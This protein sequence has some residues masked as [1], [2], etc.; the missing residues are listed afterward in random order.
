MATRQ[1]RILSRN[2]AIAATA[3]LVPLLVLIVVLAVLQFTAQRDQLLAELQEDATRHNV[4]LSGVVK[5]VR[6]YVLS[7][8]TWAEHYAGAGREPERAASA[9]APRPP[10]QEAH[11][12]M[13]SD[14]L[15]ADGE[16]EQGLAASLSPHMQVSHRTMP[17]LRWSYYFSAGE[18]LFGLFPPPDGQF[19]GGVRSRPREDEVFEQLFEYEIFRSGTPEHNRDRRGYWTEAYLDPGGAGWVVAHALPVY[20]GE[21]FR[22]IVGTAVLLDFLTGFV[23][24]FDYPCGRLWLVNDRDQVLA[25]SDGRTVTGLDLLA[26]ADVLP[27]SLR[28]LPNDQLLRPFE[29]VRRIG[30]TY[31]LSQPVGMAPWHLLF[32]VTPDELNQVLLP[33]FVPYALILAGILLTLLLAH[34]LRQRLIIGPALSL[35]E[36]IRAESQDGH[37]TRPVL[38]AVWRPW[39]DAVADAFAAKRESLHS[40]RE[41]EQH[42][43]AL[44]ELHPVPVVVSRIEDSTV[45]H[46]NQAYA[47][48]FATGREDVLAGPTTRFYVNPEDRQR[49]VDAVRRHGAVEGLETEGRRADGTTFPAVLTSRLIEFQGAEAIVS[50]VVDL[51]ERKR[52]EAEIARQ[53]EALRESEQ[54]FRTIAEAHPVPM[55]ILRRS[56]RRIL[57]A[58]Q[59]FAELMGMTLEEVYRRSSKQFYP[60]G[61]ERRR[62]AQALRRDR[63]IQD[64][65]V[66]AQRLDGSTFPAAVTAQLIEYE[67]E[68]AG[69]FGIVDLSEPKA[70]QAEIARQRE[71]LHQSEK[72]NALGALLASVAHELNNPLSVVVGYATMMRDLAPDEATKDRAVRIH[73]AAE[74][75]A[76]IVKTFL[77]M[78]R[79]KP[80]SRGAVQVNQIIEAA[81]EVAGYGLRTADISVSLDLAPD[82]PELSGDADQL[83][84]VFMNLVVNAQQALQAAPPPRRLQI[85]TA[86]EGASVRIEITDNGPGIPE[87]IRARIFEP[88]FTT[89]PQGVGT[90]IGLSVCHSLVT[91]H[92]GEISVGPAPDGGSRFVVLLPTA[93]VEASLPA[94]APEVPSRASG[95]I[96]VVE[97]EVEIADMLAEMLGRDGHEVLVAG[98]GREALERLD[99]QPVDLIISDLHMADLDGPELY[100]TLMERWPGR[101]GRMVFM[102]GDVLGAD[103]ADFLRQA[104]L[105]VFDKPIDPYEIRIKVRA[106]LASLGRA[107]E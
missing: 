106:H 33:R 13:R 88:F 101:A 98:S 64:F 47:D 71:A 84:L 18:D 55:Y 73:A 102:T 12:F 100:K 78:A 25:A 60:I 21:R 16:A 17:Y 35:L 96:L 66:T 63:A 14:R 36:Y 62:I 8:G 41:R 94:A 70:T 81:L 40:V 51:T 38:P 99:A 7:L 74:R 76:R 9:G 31:V 61:E 72:L 44:A 43:K 1:G 91:A 107:A 95:R 77:A 92:G 24:A 23:R 103:M 82:L 39:L 46:C 26:L 10:H 97:D 93:T 3:S 53:R 68:E 4:M 30:D 57:Y 89:K 11:L 65:E 29:G 20:R 58:S 27:A 28:D 105:P 86:Q 48:L 87:E 79:R 32:V 85:V 6:D 37:P 52:A 67:G 56:D 104:R 49:L 2:Y 45:L 54:R 15:R 83:T 5:S 34:Q 80:E 50:G 69:V 90:G 42:F 22:G 19:P 59:R 75:C